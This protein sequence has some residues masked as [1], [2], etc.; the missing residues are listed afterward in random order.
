MKAEMKMDL[1]QDTVARPIG[2]GWALMNK[3]E[4]GLASSALFYGN[5]DQ[6]VA[7]WNVRT[8]AHGVDEHGPFVRI[9]REV[10]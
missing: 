2:K 6:I 7:T 10:A 8:G 9:H 4:T 1:L 5:L 3:Q